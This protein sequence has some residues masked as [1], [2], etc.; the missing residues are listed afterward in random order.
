[1]WSTCRTLPVVNRTLCSLTVLTRVWSTCRTLPMVNRTLQFNC[2]NSVWSTCRT[3]PMV[4]RTL[5]SL[6]VLTRVWSSC[7]TLPV[8]IRTL[9]LFSC[10]NCVVH[11]Q[12]TAYG[13]QDTL[14]CN[15]P[16]LTL[17]DTMLILQICRSSSPNLRRPGMLLS[18]S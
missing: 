8:V 17:Q 18:N 10:P 15:F 2:P 1:M 7:R 4:N 6:T 14:V 12:D 11:L 5:C 16:V 3:L 9:C 13:Y